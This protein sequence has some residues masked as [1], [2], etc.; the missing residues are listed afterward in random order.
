MAKGN[1]EWEDPAV[2]EIRPTAA[3]AAQRVA[4]IIEAVERAASGIIDETEEGARRYLDEAR[5]QADN[6]VAERLSEATQVAS[7][8][9]ENAERLRDEM[10]ELIEA[11]DAARVRLTK[12]TE[13]S[14]AP[15]PRQSED[16]DRPTKLRRGLRRV[17]GTRVDEQAI[18]IDSQEDRGAPAF[19]DRDASP[20]GANRISGIR[21]LATQMAMA[22]STR[23]KVQS[24]LEGELPRDEA[25]RILEAVFGPEA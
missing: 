25:G 14:E 4:T 20:R 10:D 1:G 19:E 23:E 11:L 17:S 2:T 12:I 16:T 5:V 13:I 18:E 7:G 22:G 6:R 24:Y 21:L 3:S 9:I 8:L 15:E